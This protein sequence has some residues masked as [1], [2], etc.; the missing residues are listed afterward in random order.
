MARKINAFHIRSPLRLLY[1]ER[2]MTSSCWCAHC[3]MQ[4]SHGPKAGVAGAG[5][6]VQV[7]QWP[8][9]RPPRLLPCLVPSPTSLKEK[10]VKVNYDRKTVLRLWG[11]GPFL[12]SAMDFAESWLIIGNRCFFGWCFMKSMHTHLNL[13]LCIRRHGQTEHHVSG[14][15][16]QTFLTFHVCGASGCCM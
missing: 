13:F 2:L 16:G 10:Q 9:S 7:L 14:R 11:R 3:G 5:S 1:P 15:F 12:L 4:R 8:T 6:F